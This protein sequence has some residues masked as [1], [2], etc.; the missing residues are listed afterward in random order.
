MVI[1]SMTENSIVSVIV[2][3][4]N[5]AEFL[6]QCMESLLAQ[7]YPEVEIILVDD[8]STDETGSVCDRY[9]SEYESVKV[10][11]QN[12]QGQSVAR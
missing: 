3:A 2:P 6:P 11:H 4:Y 12:N 8:G 5:C 7:S 9:A 10:F 1:D